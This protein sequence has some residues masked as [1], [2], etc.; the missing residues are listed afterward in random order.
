MITRRTKVQLLVFAI[1]TLLGVTFVGAR[2]AQL[3]RLIVDQSYTVVA[4]YPQSGGIFAGGEV[5]YRGVRVGKVSELEL[6]KDGVD[7]VLQIDNEWDE[8]PTD[9][10]ALVGKD[11]H[12]RGSLMGAV[13]QHHKA[14]IVMR[15]LE[16]DEI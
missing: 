2:Y 11:V 12:L 4:H 3:D 13:T 5:T 1:I 8:I 6:T 7:V 14:P 9:T 10:R 15:V 16:A